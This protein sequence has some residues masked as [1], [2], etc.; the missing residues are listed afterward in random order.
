[1]V[2][3][4]LGFEIVYIAIQAKRKQLSHFNQSAPFYIFMYSL[5]GFAATVVTF[6]TAY[7]GL[8]FCF[9][10][11]PNLPDY[12]IWSIRFGILIFVV[13][14]FEGF[15]MGSRL[16]HTI[17]G[18]MGGE[19]IPILNW[20]TKFGD[21]R[22]AHFIGMH[23]LQ[24]LPLLSYFILKNTFLVFV[25]AILYFALSVFTLRQALRG[26]PF[27]NFNAPSI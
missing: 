19:G 25:L 22:V 21:P 5:M 27:Y 6:Y 10:R 11:F 15:V 23:A 8:L 12:Y 2:I 9:T 16:T 24:V 1:M 20:S 26:K 13:F 4:L 3:I 14:A 7:V 17:G 18:E